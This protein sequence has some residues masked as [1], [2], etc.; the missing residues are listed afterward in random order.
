[1]SE[2]AYSTFDDDLVAL[3]TEVER[4]PEATQPFE[5]DPNVSNSLLAVDVGTVNTRAILFDAVENRYRFLAGGRGPT[6]AGAPMY[7]ASEGVRYAIDTLERIAG[8]VL[9]SQSAEL[10]VPS[11]ADGAGADHLAATFSGAAPLKVVVAGLLEEVS[12]RSAHN[13]IGSTYT[14]MVASIG[15]SERNLNKQISQIIN[16]Q[17]DVI[18]IAG[19]TNGGASRSVLRLVNALG[20]AV[21]LMPE[22][23]RP[24]VLFVGNEALAERVDGF[25]EQ[26]TTVHLAPNIR[27]SLKHEQLG[28]AEI[29]L[30]DIFRQR[31]SERIRGI[32][33]LNI[34]SNG[35]LQPTSS[36]FG[37]VIRFLSQVVPSADKGVL[38]IDVGAAATT[39]AAAFDGDLRLSVYTEMGMGTGLDSVLAHRQLEDIMRWIP[40][41]VSPSYVLDY[42]QNKIVYPGTLPATRQDIAI[43]QALTREVTRMALERA[44]SRFPKNVMRI[45]GHFPMFNPIMVRGSALADA[46]TLAQAMLMILDSVEPTGVQQIILDTNHIAPALGAAAPVNPLLVSQLLFD[47]VAFSNLGY[48]IAPAVNAKEGQAVLRIRMRYDTGHENTIEVKQGNLQLIPLPTGRRARLY[49]DPLRRADIGNGPGR[50]MTVESVTGGPFGIVIDARGRPLQIPTDPELRLKTLQRWHIALGR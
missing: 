30:A 5:L 9:T 40:I 37:R 23:H 46:P 36:S 44:E 29:Q 22:N 1:M 12:L 18:V 17:P 35:N 31:Y 16:A 20:M 45:G 49:I 26:L 8:R 21:H 42:I 6:T 43:E 47:P 48:V 14:N 41:K 4:E 25:L 10:I 24:D 15:L 3:P 32:D 34:W 13:L 28:P 39:V 27:P 11:T 50:S 19:G 2:D 33:E 7:D 38:G